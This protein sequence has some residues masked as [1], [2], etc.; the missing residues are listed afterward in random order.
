MTIAGSEILAVNEITA[1]DEEDD[2]KE[3]ERKRSLR[4]V[5]PRKMTLPLTLTHSLFC[6]ITNYFSNIIKLQPYANN[7]FQQQ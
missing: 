1:Y 2:D 3:E 4:F 6:F 5:L 7:T